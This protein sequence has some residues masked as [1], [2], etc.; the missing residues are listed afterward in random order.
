MVI[1]YGGTG[2]ASPRARDVVLPWPAWMRPETIEETGDLMAGTGGHGEALVVE[3]EDP[4]A[5]VDLV[6]QIESGRGRLDVLVNDI[7]GGDRNAEWDTPLWEHDLAGGLRMLRMGVD[8]HLI[9]AHA[10]L[11]LLLRGDRGLRCGRV[12]AGCMGLHRCLRHGGTER[13]KRRAV[14]LREGTVPPSRKA[15]PFGPRRPRPRRMPRS[16]PPSRFPI[17]RET[18]RMLARTLRKPFLLRV[19]PPAGPGRPSP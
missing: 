7:L 18:I 9:T 10:A 5:V 14:P 16:A 11:P 19:V 2:R 12:T 6:A 13:E 8:T 15:I 1:R 17:L 4:V 3:H